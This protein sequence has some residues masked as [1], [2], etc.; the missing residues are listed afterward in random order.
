MFAATIIKLIVVDDGTNASYN[1]NFELSPA[2][3]VPKYRI[4]SCG[5]IRL[6]LC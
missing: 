4:Q 5:C 6:L 3:V 2:A 1:T